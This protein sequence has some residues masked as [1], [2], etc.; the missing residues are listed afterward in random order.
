MPVADPSIVA[1]AIASAAFRFDDPDAFR[2]K[3]ADLIQLHIGQ[4]CRVAMWVHGQRV[5]SSPS[6]QEL[7][8]FHV[9]EGGPARRDSAAVFSPWPGFDLSC[10]ALFDGTSLTRAL[11]PVFELLRDEEPTVAARVRELSTL[12]GT[13]P[14]AESIASQSLTLDSKDVSD[15]LGPF[16]EAWD[17][18]V[19]LVVE[20]NPLLASWGDPPLLSNCFTVVRYVP[21]T[22]YSRVVRDKL[23]REQHYKYTAKIL[24]SRSAQDGLDSIGCDRDSIEAPLGSRGRFISD[25]VFSTGVLYVADLREREP[26]FGDLQRDLPASSSD[27]SRHEAEGRFYARFFPGAT[28]A[29]FVPIHVGET[30]WLS[31]YQFIR[32]NS[33]RALFRFYRDEVGPLADRAR[34]AARHAFLGCLARDLGDFARGGGTIAHLNKLNDEWFKAS[35]V[36]PFPVIRAESVDNNA[37]G[38]LDVGPARLGLTIDE[39]SRPLPRQVHH[40]SMT[41]DDVRSGLKGDAFELAHHF[42][43]I[44]WR[45]DSMAQAV[46][47]EFKNLS[48]ELAVRAKNLDALVKSHVT[49]QSVLA[50]LRG[51]A[52]EGQWLNAISL[53]LFDLTSTEASARFEESSESVAL[54]RAALRIMLELRA[55]NDRN[56]R[57]H[58]DLTFSDAVKF[59]ESIYGREPTVAHRWNPWRAL[60]HL[61][62]PPAALLLFAAAEPVRNVRIDELAQGVDPTITAWTAI[63][64]TPG[65]VLLF[66][67]ATEALYTTRSPMYSK[68]AA[69]ANTILPPNFCSI[70]TSVMPAPDPNFTTVGNSLR[71]RR[72]TTITAVGRPKPG[73]QK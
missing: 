62:K 3:L 17:R 40:E 73:V 18:T 65:T 32:P 52:I 66:Q 19:A 9:G 70:M 5:L 49:E 35:M 56:L 68:G 71:V 47:H 45:T 59:L 57:V 44:K 67:E 41:L 12:E 22:N 26:G 38:D 30:P 29:I 6:E 63:G 46:A 69:R 4:A 27:H 55:Q 16:R 36:F 39:E 7:A 14:P 53:G 20:H 50:A 15:R 24:L 58:D 1:D 43:D 21:A 60:P 54:L 37:G 64:V 34:A 2:I 10:D 33:W 28:Q 11:E 13:P 61:M 48:G 51:I 42:A 72:I 8:A 23:G 31:L 25:T